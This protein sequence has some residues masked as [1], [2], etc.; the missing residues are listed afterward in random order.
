MP[1][2]TRLA[3]VIW[4]AFIVPLRKRRRKRQDEEEAAWQKS[5]HF[6]YALLNDAQ[7]HDALGKLGRHETTLMNTFTKTLQILLLLQENRGTKPVI[8]EAVSLPA[9]A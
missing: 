8:L 4:A 1:A 9:A 3:I 5:V 2:T 6:G 7:R